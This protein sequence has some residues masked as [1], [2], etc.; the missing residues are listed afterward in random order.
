MVYPRVCRGSSGGG[1]AFS[2]IGGLSPRVRGKP[3]RINR[4][5]SWT[6]SIPAC[7]GEAE[8][9]AYV[10]VRKAVYPRVC[11]GSMEESVRRAG[12]AGLSPR[13]RGKRSRC[14]QP[15][16]ARGSIPACAGEAAGSCG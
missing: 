4:A 13:V 14:R 15:Q 9:T 5:V 10:K 2:V 1:S 8:V 11:G 6:R 12:Q 7:A 3:Q 16:P